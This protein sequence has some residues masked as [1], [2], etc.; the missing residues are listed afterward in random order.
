MHVEAALY[1]MEVELKSLIKQIDN[2]SWHLYYFFDVFNAL[3]M[4]LLVELL[5]VSWIEKPK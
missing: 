5:N 4:L 2:R 3:S 1:L